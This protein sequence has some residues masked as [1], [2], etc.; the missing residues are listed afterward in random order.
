M[1]QTAGLTNLLP[2]LPP[3]P[4]SLLPLLPPSLLLLL[5]PLGILIC[6]IRDLLPKKAAKWVPSPMAMSIP[7]YIG[8]ASVSCECWGLFAGCVR[9]CGIPGG[10]GTWRSLSCPLSDGRKTLRVLRCAALCCVVLCRRS[11]S[12]WVL[13]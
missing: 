8:A 9:G 5:P 12:G 10:A 2:L 11:I 13:W 1:R 7:F 4:P 3:L 6:M